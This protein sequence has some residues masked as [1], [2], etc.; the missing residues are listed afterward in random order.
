MVSFLAE[1]KNVKDSR[2]ELAVRSGII[3]GSG[4]GTRGLAQRAALPRFIPMLVNS[5]TFPWNESPPPLLES[6]V[7]RQL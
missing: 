3:H 7:K 2:I 5:Q 4:L 1:W 6:K